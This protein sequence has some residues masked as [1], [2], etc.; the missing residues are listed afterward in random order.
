[1]KEVFLREPKV[2]VTDQDPTM[3]VTIE[4]V[5]VN[6]KH[7]FFMCHIMEKLTSKVGTSIS[8]YG[9]KRKISRI[10]WTDRLEPAEFDD[11]WISIVNE[12]MRTTSHSESENH[13]FRRLLNSDLTF[14]EFFSHFE[15][16]VQ[17]H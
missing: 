3:K 11:K 8:R 13:M 5:F 2:V 6:A 17:T 10:I 7:R 12:I 1:F 9:F 4:K 16:A 14:V 15:T